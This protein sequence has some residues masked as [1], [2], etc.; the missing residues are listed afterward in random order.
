MEGKYLRTSH[1]N[2]YRLRRAP[3]LRRSGSWRTRADLEVCPTFEDR[4]Q[5]LG[6]G[7]VDHPVAERRRRNQARLGIAY[8]EA[9]VGAG[10]VRPIPQLALQP[11]NCGSKSS[12]NAATSGRVRLPAAARRAASSRLGKEING[13]QRPPTRFTIAPPQ[14]SASH[15]PWGTFG[16]VAGGWWLVVSGRAFA[17]RRRERSPVTLR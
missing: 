9:T 14:T 3:G 10:S 7:M 6:Q 13:G 17:R 1:F 15:P 4:L 8:G 5:H 16:A 11:A 2:T 12:R